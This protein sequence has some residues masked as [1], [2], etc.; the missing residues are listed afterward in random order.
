M[1]LPNILDINSQEVDN[2]DTNTLK[3]LWTRLLPV[4]VSTEEGEAEGGDDMEVVDGSEDAVDTI[5]RDAQISTDS[6]SSHFSRGSSSALLAAEW[7]AKDT[8][9]DS[10]LLYMVL[11]SGSGAAETLL[12]VRVTLSSS[13]ISPLT[14]RVVS[15]LSLDNSYL[16][17]VEYIVLNAT[18]TRLALFAASCR[19]LNVYSTHSSEVDSGSSSVTRAELALHCTAIQS[20]NTVSAPLDFA[21]IGFVS[22]SVAMSGSTRGQVRDK[23]QRPWDAS[24]GDVL[25]AAMQTSP[26]EIAFSNKLVF[27]N[28]ASTPSGLSGSAAGYRTCDLPRGGL[29]QLAVIPCYAPHS[30]ASHQNTLLSSPLLLLGLDKGHR[31]FRYLYAPSSDF[32]GP[33]YP[34]GYQLVIE[35]VAY[36]E[37]E[38]EL[39]RVVPSARKEGMSVNIVDD[40]SSKSLDMTSPVTPPGRDSYLQR[41]PFTLPELFSPTN[42]SSGRPPNQQ[43]GGH[44]KRKRKADEA[45]LLNNA[46][47]QNPIKGIQSAPS[48]SSSIATAAVTETVEQSDSEGEGSVSGEEEGDLDDIKSDLNSS[49]FDWTGGLRFPLSESR[50]QEEILGLPSRIVTGDYFSKL[51][52]DRDFGQHTLTLCNDANS[53][54]ESML[55][56]QVEAVERA[57]AYE[58]KKEK[59]RV[60]REE[61]NEEK[62]NKL[63]EEQRRIVTA[64]V[65]C[66]DTAT[67]VWFRNSFGDDTAFGGSSDFDSSSG[68]RN[69]RNGP[70]SLIAKKPE[71]TK[72]EKAL[73]KVKSQ[74]GSRKK[75]HKDT[76]FEGGKKSQAIK[77]KME[78]SKLLFKAMGKGGLGNTVN[79]YKGSKTKRG[80]GSAVQRSQKRK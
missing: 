51:K 80:G 16:S 10:C 50:L 14:F 54:R 36:R 67:T 57:V 13:K 31:L 33:M 74:L 52:R 17:R 29:S 3:A 61:K 18:G 38:D 15:T 7:L 37:A 42:T 35:C 68:R 60:R 22:R 62:R 69:G 39:D 2:T 73:K 12:Q 24:D 55:R 59:D 75:K 21:G 72:M 11:N 30:S 76:S 43:R 71:L 25:V 56:L 8:N 70:V 9:D 34:V 28:I 32:P 64:N 45:L 23:T 26:G 77:S 1:S 6:S 40:R 47:S 79:A 41:L 46:Q 27:A 49:V 63:V 58:E 65:V 20:T 4:V 48:S 53:V 19:A 44:R 66:S 5:D 78:S